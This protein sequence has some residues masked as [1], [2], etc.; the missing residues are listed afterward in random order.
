MIYVEYPFLGYNVSWLKLFVRLSHVRLNHATP[1]YSFCVPLFVFTG[2]NVEWLLRLNSE[3]C[4]WSNVALSGVY[5]ALYMYLVMGL[6][7][8]RILLVIK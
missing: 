6:M 2:L 8:F 3:H 7:N 1:P 5:D 4:L